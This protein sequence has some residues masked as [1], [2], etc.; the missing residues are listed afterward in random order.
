M[1]CYQRLQG[2]EAT[3]LPSYRK[4][5]RRQSFPTR[6]A[7]PTRDKQLGSRPSAC[8]ELL[9]VLA[10]GVHS[11]GLHQR[12]KQPRRQ[13][14]L[15]ARARPLAEGVLSIHLKHQLH[16]RLK[17]L[18][19]LRRLQRQSIKTQKQGIVLSKLPGASECHA[20]QVQQRSPRRQRHS[21]TKSLAM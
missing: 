2:I 10:V 6:V 5:A 3:Q 11:K 14:L 19:C 15:E 21:T 17:Q 7:H 16:G 13:Q 18:L 20:R 8:L 12:V 1:E 9:S 4:T